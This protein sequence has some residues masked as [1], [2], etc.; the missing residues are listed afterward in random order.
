MAGFRISDFGLWIGALLAALAVS[1]CSSGSSEQP[2]PRVSS[3]KAERDVVDGQAKLTSV[4]KV[5]LD[6]DFKV[7]ES[8]LPLASNFELSVPLAEGG[9]QRVL[10]QT[11]KVA[12]G[13]G[14]VIELK[15]ASLIPQ[16]T[17]LSVRRSLFQADATGN[18]EAKVDSDLDKTLVVLASKALMSSNEA[19]LGDPE[20]APLKPEDRDPAAMRQALEAHMQARQVDPQT[21]QD[22]LDLYDAIPVEVV[23][24]PKL[25][26]ALAALTGT[27]AEPA[28]PSLLT[29]SNCTGKPANRIAFQEP[30]GNPK[31]LAQVTHIGDGSRVVSINPF[32][33]GERFEYLMPILAHEAV[34]CDED[35]SL[36]EE[37]A[38]T[39]FD[40]F[41]YLQLIAIEPALASGHTR[42]AREVNFD[43]VAM[44]NSGSVLPE[45]AGILPSV[46]VRQ[47][48][49]GTNAP[50]GSFAEFVAR[51]YAQLGAG[52]SKTEPLATQY[53]QILAIAAGMPA[54]DAF[55][56]RY[57]DEV[58][59]RAMPVG[60]LFE[61]ITALQL[62]PEG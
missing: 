32:A 53:T 44:I 31:L 33:E 6:R 35:D 27:F 41:L 28:I 9:N 2:L 25:R 46:G 61:S 30:P 58:V 7:V 22:A 55:D 4:I 37:V 38:A 1:A 50:Q 3:A 23:T 14:R 43:A 59:G 19:F 40:G 18:I 39:A 13:T 24:S 54:G 45:S 16:D 15:V 56:L 12:G 57:L 29:T 52:S 10:V 48:L 49:P 51:A 20:T 11:A 5:Q 17:K 42:V 60:A 21:L 34:H 36:A 26:A 62:E 8:G 47:V